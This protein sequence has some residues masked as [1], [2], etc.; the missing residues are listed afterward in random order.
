MR[1]FRVCDLSNLN[2]AAVMSQG[3]QYENYLPHSLSGAWQK[4]HSLIGLSSLR[5]SLATASQ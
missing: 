3:A 4:W 2:G 1:A 5:A